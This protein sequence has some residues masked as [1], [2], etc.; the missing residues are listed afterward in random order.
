MKQLFLALAL[1]LTACTQPVPVPVSVTPVKT[2]WPNEVLEKRA[3]AAIHEY[4]SDLVHS[5]PSDISKWCALDCN[6]EGMFLEL[7]SALAFHESSYKE[8]AAMFEK[9]TDA[10]GNRVESVGLLQ[11]S[12]DDGK[13]YGCDI[14]TRADLVNPQKNLNCGVKI[15]TKLTLQDG[16]ISGGI[17]GAWKGAAKYWSPFRKPEFLAL[18]QK[19]TKAVQ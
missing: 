14:V 15:L 3:L 1:L 17:P 6:Q 13:R 9:F 10:K 11:L 12:I 18:M 19:K 7:L 5:S 4:G 2:T 16:V 8:S